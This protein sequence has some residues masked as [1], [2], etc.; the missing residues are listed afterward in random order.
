MSDPDFLWLEDVDGPRSMEWVQ[1]RNTESLARLEGDA[2]YD[3]LK[4]SA[5]EIY[6]SDD[7]IPYVTHSQGYVHNFWQDDVHVKGIWRRAAI[8]PYLADEAEWETLLDV[9]ALAKAEDEDWVYKGRTC[10]PPDKQRC[11]VSLSR[12]GSDAVEIREFDVPTRNFVDGGFVLPEAKTS[13]EWLDPDHLLVATDF[14][15]GSLTTSGYPRMVKKWRRGTSLDQAELLFTAELTDMA[16]SPVTIHRAEGSYA[17]LVRLPTFFSQ[18]IY[19]LAADG[20]QKLPLP[21]DVDFQGMFF[22]RVI[23]ELRSDW[24]VDEQT[25][26]TGSLVAVDLASLL[27]NET[28]LKVQAVL[29]PS[30]ERAIKGVSLGREA[31]YVSVMEH[32]NG[33]LLKIRPDAGS[34]VA[35]TV[36]FPARGSIDVVTNDALA[37]ILMVNYESFLAPSSLYVVDQH[38]K[39]QLIRSLRERFP[40]DQYV[41]EQHFAVSKDGTRVPYYVVASKDLVRDGSAPAYIYA[42]G[43]FQVSLTPGYLSAMGIEWL[44]AGGV[45]VQANLRGGG[46]YGPQWHQAALKENRQRAFDDLIAVSEDLIANKITSPARLAIR[47][48]SN[49]GLLV[50]AVMAQRPELFGAVIC[51][52]PLIDMLRYHKLSAGASWVA[53][54]GNPDVPEEAAYI[55]EYSPMQNVG[56]DVDYPETFFWTN[57]LDDRVHPSHAR[58]MA[59]KMQAQEHSVLYYENTEGGHGGGADPFAQAHTTALELVFM[60]QE[61]VDEPK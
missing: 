29:T 28:P 8:G 32:V 37:D 2:R 42:Y 39:P 12:G 51:A 27:A 55:A 13:V 16:V 20:L 47:G 56:P 6:T 44:K 15:A 50:T 3:T 14:G 52:V 34:W 58:R 35:D 59:A 36:D 61:L 4:A 22:D 11:L 19:H 17:F 43:G 25:I 46:E 48:G 24:S 54:Y 26:P 5:I 7:R 41:S 18:D 33:A 40:A 10:L 53:E 45:F 57:T 31:I 49:G 60:M 21:D 23:A 1:A 38:A 9:D 30:T